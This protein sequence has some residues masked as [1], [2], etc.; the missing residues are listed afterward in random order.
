[1][2]AQTAWHCSPLLCQLHSDGIQFLSVRLLSGSLDKPSFTLT[3]CHLL[4]ISLLS[5]CFLYFSHF[6]DLYPSRLW[7]MRSWCCRMK[8]VNYRRV[9]LRSWQTATAMGR[10]ATSW[11][12]SLLSPCWERGW[13]PFEWR[14]LVNGSCWRYALKYAIN[15]HLLH[16]H[17][18]IL[19]YIVPHTLNLICPSHWIL[20][21]RLSE[22][23][24]E[25]RQ[26]QALQRYHSEAEELDHWLLSTRAT[27]SSALQPL[28][29]DLDMEEQLI[30]CQVR[31]TFLLSSKAQL[32]WKNLGLVHEDSQGWQFG[33][34]F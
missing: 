23:L 1:M 7:W 13:P 6:S 16:L 20:Q 12:C 25:Q 21:E 19:I 22:Q 26:E 28:N 18:F 29:E 5:G 34:S 30:D 27:L 2:V 9:S 10:L 31:F 3:S 24:E 33:A 17:T 11:L 14:L 4:Q 8:S 15:L 32:F